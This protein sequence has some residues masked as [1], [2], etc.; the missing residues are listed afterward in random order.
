VELQVAVP[1]VAEVLVFNRQLLVLPHIMLA[2]VAV[3]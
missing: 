3:A 1:L 2:A